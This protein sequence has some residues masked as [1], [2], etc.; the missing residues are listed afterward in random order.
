MNDSVIIL[1]DIPDYRIEHL[2][3]EHIRALQGL[4]EKCT[5]YSELVTGLPPDSSSAQTLLVDHPEEKS[6]D[7][8]YVIG[9]FNI[10][11]ELVGVLD[12]V[13]N[14]PVQHE[15]WLGLLLLDPQYRSKGLGRQVYYQ[16]EQWVSR[17]GVQSIWLGVVEQNERACQFWR[18]MGFEPIE[19][20]QPIRM[21]N[22]ENVVLVMKR[23][24]SR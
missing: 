7:D 22:L 12:V 17:Q 9:V 3:Q 1:F 16:F 21:G 15:W 8:K 20:R 19:R 2:R 11:G 13:R 4:L 24:V 10:E 14:Y 23:S 6:L 5:D 18:S